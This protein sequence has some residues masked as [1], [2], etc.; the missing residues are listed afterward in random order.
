MAT[1]KKKTTRSKV[2]PDQTQKIQTMVA[3]AVSEWYNE[4][5]TYEKVKAQVFR[6]L[7]KDKRV[8]MAK[9]LGFN[10]SR[11]GDEPWEVDHCNGRSGESV[12]GQAIA[13]AVAQST[14]DWI[15]KIKKANGNFKINT[16]MQR[17]LKKDFQERF[18]R[19]ADEQI[20][21]LA[22]NRAEETIRA[23]VDQ[24]MKDHTV[25]DLLEPEPSK[26]RLRGRR[27]GESL[28]FLHWD[29]EDQPE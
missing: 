25:F 8:I 19:E 20:R 12:A 2:S 5:D 7:N 13:A 23:L 24:T 9:V 26:P 1:A 16:A 27:M 11:W 6:I 29:E 14:R 15:E 3:K 28:D 21:R 10:T 18:K 17:A 22:S 4:N